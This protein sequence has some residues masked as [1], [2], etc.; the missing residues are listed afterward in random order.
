MKVLLLN[1]V[2]ALG[3]RFE[4]KEVA[5]G[6]ARNFLIPKG[7]AIIADVAAHKRVEFLK[8]KQ[9]NEDKNQQTRVEN[10]IKN[11]SDQT[12]KIEAKANAQGHLF[13]GLDE[14]RIVAAIK[15]Q[16]GIEAEEKWL[17]LDRPIKV[18]GEHELTITGGKLSGQIKLIVTAS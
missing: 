3:Q 2:P 14:K 7:L 13:E 1:N 10:I 4:L 8:T 11:L 16:T 6:H 5:S 17:K 18:T 12:L 9:F 15:S